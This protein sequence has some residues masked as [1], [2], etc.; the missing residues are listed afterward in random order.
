[1][2]LKLSYLDSMSKIDQR[3]PRTKSMVDAGG[4][5]VPLPP[6]F[7]RFTTMGDKRA[8]KDKQAKR[9]VKAVATA[10]SAAAKAATLTALVERK[11]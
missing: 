11:K 6:P 1:M 4:G 7:D 9:R 5:D 3:M 10:Q 8:N 2:R